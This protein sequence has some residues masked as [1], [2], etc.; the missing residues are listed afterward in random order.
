[1][2][3]GIKVRWENQVK[4]GKMAEEV[5]KETSGS[6]ARLVTMV[7]KE[8]TECRVPLDPPEQWS[9]EKKCLVQQDL[10]AETACLEQLVNQVQRE[11]EENEVMLEEMGRLENLG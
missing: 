2:I 4:M 6:L 10:Q 9:K 5:R 7:D 1:M 11:K 8:E 3:Q